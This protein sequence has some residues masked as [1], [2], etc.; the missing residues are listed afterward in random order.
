MQIYLLLVQ[1][2][3]F[4]Y[5]SG[6]SKEEWTESQE[7]D[8]VIASVKY[9]GGSFVFD[10]DRCLLRLKCVRMTSRHQFDHQGFQDERNHWGG[11][12]CQ[13]FGLPA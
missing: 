5:G 13:L 3:A 10:L 4:E 11:N 12:I 1:L 6:E 9:W 7:E 8:C 2:S